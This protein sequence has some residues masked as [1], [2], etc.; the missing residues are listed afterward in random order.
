MPRLFVGPRE[1][2]FF[3]DISREVIKDIVGQVVY[4]YSIDYAKTMVDELYRESPEKVFDHPVK[5]DVRVSWVP[6]EV[7]TDQFGHDEVRQIDVFV[8]VRDVVGKRLNLATGDYLSFG[9]TFYEVVS[10]VF[11]DI[12]FGQPEYRMGYKLTC[13]QARRDEFVAKLIGPTWEGNSDADAVQHD[14]HQQRGFEHNR[15]GQTGDVHDLVQKG[16]LDPPLGGPREVSQ[17]GSDVADD[18]AF[19]D[20][21]DEEPAE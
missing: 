7:K 9:E 3:N 19:Y 2:D 4:Y 16:V 5:L 14:F 12:V 10:C 20:E 21:P 6:T 17:R 13:V 15:E 18:S 8:H 11:D 1:I